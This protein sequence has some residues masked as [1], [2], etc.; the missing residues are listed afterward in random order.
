[1]WVCLFVKLRLFKWSVGGD[2]LYR[3][4]WLIWYLSNYFPSDLIDSLRSI[5]M[6][7]ACMLLGGHYHMSFLQILVENTI[8][9]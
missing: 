8:R 2:W 3:S 4:L 9:M 6:N 1:M 5:L 7:L